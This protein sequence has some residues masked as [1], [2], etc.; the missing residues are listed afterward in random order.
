MKY[1]PPKGIP[2]AIIWPHSLNKCVSPFCARIMLIPNSTGLCIEC[3]H[4][5]AD[6]LGGYEK[7]Y[8]YRKHPIKLLLDSREIVEWITTYEYFKEK[9]KEDENVFANIKNQQSNE[10][11]NNH[12]TVKEV[13]T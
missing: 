3:F 9:S 12:Q 11:K 7:I 1:E 4:K 6:Q 10:P 13:R 5:L 2:D 8:D